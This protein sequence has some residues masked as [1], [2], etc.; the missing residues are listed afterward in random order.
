MSY[1]RGSA[2]LTPR[3]REAETLAAR[4][5]NRRQ[6]AQ[7][8]G[9]TRSHVHQMLMNIEDKRRRVAEAQSR[10]AGLDPLDRPIILQPLSNRAQNSLAHA[11]YRTL[12]EIAEFSDEQ[13]LRIK[14]FGLTSLR[15]VRKLLRKLEKLRQTRR[16]TSP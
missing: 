10:C 4:G 11:G 9:V 8:L 2:N 14:N 6:I 13:M 12:R 16:S 1:E 3:E 5:L 15:E 7:Q